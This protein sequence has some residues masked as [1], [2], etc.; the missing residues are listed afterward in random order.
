MQCDSRSRVKS[1]GN[2]AYLVLIQPINQV[3]HI[4]YNYVSCPF[5]HQKSPLLYMF[6]T[7]LYTYIH[8]HAYVTVYAVC[9]ILATG[10]KPSASDIPM[11]ITWKKNGFPLFSIKFKNFSVTTWHFNSACVFITS[12][13]RL[14]WIYNTSYPTFEVELYNIFIAHKK[15]AITFLLRVRKFKKN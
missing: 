10:S 9:R 1:C 15:P 14:A 6:Y 13:M 3:Q 7:S 8:V 5:A 12:W 4:S 2:S 11:I